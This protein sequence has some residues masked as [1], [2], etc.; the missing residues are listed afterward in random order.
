MCSLHF[1]ED[2]YQMTEDRPELK[3]DAVPLVV[4]DEVEPPAKKQRKPKENIIPLVPLDSK[5]ENE[6]NKT[7]RTLKQKVGRKNKRIKLCKSLLKNIE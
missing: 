6:L 7:N 4:Q 3:V 1:V 5:K 2:N